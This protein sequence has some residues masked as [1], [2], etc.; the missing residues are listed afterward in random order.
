M[1]LTPVFRV[2]LEQTVHYI[3]Y[4]QWV[5]AINP[6]LTLPLLMLLVFTDHKKHPL[7]ANNFAV[8]TDL[9]Y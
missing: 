5:K 3:E 8:A 9:F 2:P 4:D 6:K 1:L 7:A